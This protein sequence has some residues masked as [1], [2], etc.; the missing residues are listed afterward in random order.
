[1]AI[2]PKVFKKLTEVLTNKVVAGHYVV[3]FA[4][5]TSE[6]EASQAL[7]YRVLFKEGNGQVTPE[8]EKLGR[9]VDQWDE[10]AYHVIVTDTKRDKVVGCMRLVS[11]EKLPAGQ[12]TYTE[13]YFDLSG[14]RKKFDHPLELSRACVSSGKRDG[15]VLLLIWKFTMQ[16]INDSGFDVMFGCASFSSTEYQKHAPI[17][18]YLNQNNLAP[19]SLMPQPVVDS[20]VKVADIDF[21]EN[22]ERN[23]GLF[24]ER[25]KVPTML[26][27]YLKLGAKVSDAA[28]IDF[29]FNTT[30]LCIYV[31]AVEMRE[32]DHALV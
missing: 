24:G 17:L 23:S 9:E 28:V 8:M 18:H 7:R 31:D 16:F 32:I 6:I 5:S 27:G 12:K 2:K 29:E 1:M 14:L 10:Y 13:Q 11:T 15:I 4:R 19:E 25:L 21:D 3:A 30:F 22:D 20:H 26:R